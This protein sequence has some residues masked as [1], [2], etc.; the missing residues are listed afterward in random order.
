M[1]MVVDRP[2]GFKGETRYYLGRR[3]IFGAFP[4]SKDKLY[5]FYMVPSGHLE[6]ASRGDL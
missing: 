6:E 2:A 5:L 4:V 1:T 3:A